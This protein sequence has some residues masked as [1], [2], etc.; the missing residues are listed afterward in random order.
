MTKGC[1]KGLMSTPCLGEIPAESTELKILASYL[2]TCGKL[3]TEKGIPFL[4][5]GCLHPV[6]QDGWITM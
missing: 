4:A 2:E 3:N 5:T 6:N 1:F